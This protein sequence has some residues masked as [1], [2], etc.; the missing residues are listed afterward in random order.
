MQSVTATMIKA[1]AGG[2][3]KKNLGE[4]FVKRVRE[5]REKDNLREDKMRAMCEPDDFNQVAEIKE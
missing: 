1:E 3:S 5:E 2:M 4:L